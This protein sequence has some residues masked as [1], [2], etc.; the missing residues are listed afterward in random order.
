MPSKV[1]T[2]GGQRLTAAFEA[3]ESMPALAQSR[4][5]VMAAGIGNGAAPEAMIDAVECDPGLAIAVIRK[6][7]AR[8]SKSGAVGTVSEAVAKVGA[9]GV[10]KIASQID[11]FDFL[12]RGN[13][14]ASALERFRIHALMT[15]NAANTIS[16]RIG[17][18]DHE[19]IVLAALLHDVGKLVVARLRSPS[20][21]ATPARTPEERVAAE[22]RDLGIDH[23]LVGGV[24]ARRW[25]LPKTIA[26]A[27]ERH[28]AEDAENAAAVLRMADMLA[29]HA[30]GE[31][32]TA[33][34]LRA[35][36]KTCGIR[37]ADL[38]DLVYG[39]SNGREQRAR[40]PE[41]SPLSVRE[42]EVLRCLAEGK[43]YKQ[44][45]HELALSVSTVRTHLHNVYA[46]L[47]VIDRA[48]AVLTATDKG[49]I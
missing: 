41:P 43:V 49:W 24:L 48:Q 29:H 26:A 3:V 21:G 11:T 7:N 14:P 44:I 28:H 27:I 1:Q 47:G 15:R 23:A 2:R 32:I 40:A 42:M 4:D 18:P 17:A 12:E 19:Q 9:A 22:R 25:G 35:I 6:A 20:N 37:K 46:K 13:G 10:Q 16:Q 45:A 39:Q 36:A 34:K 31:A 30:Q 38:E 33:Q 5:K 8:A